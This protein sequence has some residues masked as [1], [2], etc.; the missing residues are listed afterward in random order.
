RL[1]VAQWGNLFSQRRTGK[2]IRVGWAGGGSHTGDLEIIQAVIKEL[3]DS[4]EWV[5]MGMKPEGIHCEFHAGV[6]FDL[7]PEK[8]ASLNLDLALVPLEIN[9][10]NECKS[11]LR[12]LEIGACGVPIIAT[13]IEPYQCGLPVTLVDNRFKDW[14]SAIKMHLADMDATSGMGDALRAAV[15]Q[16]WMLRD[17]GLDEWRKAWLDA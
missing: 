1:A 16:D 3:Q 15:H 7:Y 13:R 5:F 12:L 11:N 2:K 17:H 10:F 14:V 6:P 8:L 4:V 9:H